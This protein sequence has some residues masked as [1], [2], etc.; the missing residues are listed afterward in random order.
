MVQVQS[1]GKWAAD[2]RVIVEHNGGQHVVATVGTA[3]LRKGGSVDERR[4]RAG[5]TSQLRLSQAFRQVVS[6]AGAPW[7]RAWIRLQGWPNTEPPDTNTRY[8]FRLY[9]PLLEQ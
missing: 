6:E 1:D 2:E 5:S 9:M 7:W 3:A 8:N 4:L